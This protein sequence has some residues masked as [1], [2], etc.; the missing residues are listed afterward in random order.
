[1]KTKYKD[2]WLEH[3]TANEP[4]EMTTNKQSVCNNTTVQ[5]LSVL[6][7]ELARF[8]FELLELFREPDIVK[9]SEREC[10]IEWWK[11][12]LISASC[13]DCIKARCKASSLACSIASLLRFL[14]AVYRMR[15]MFRHSKQLA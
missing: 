13:M 5:V 8:E 1:M 12:P 4:N 10:A 14:E 11:L 15:Y 9:E 6:T 3:E 7:E 2:V